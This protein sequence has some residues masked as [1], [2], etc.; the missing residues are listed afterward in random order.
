MANQPKGSS[1]RVFFLGLLLLPNLAPS[2]LSLFDKPWERAPFV[3]F[4]GNGLWIAHLGRARVSRTDQRG[5]ISFVWVPCL[6]MA[7]GALSW[8]WISQPVTA[9]NEGF[10]W[11]GQHYAAMHSYFSAGTYAPIPPEFP[12]WQRVGLPFLAAA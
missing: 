6:I 3:Y 11:D 4:A 2:L 5:D 12:Y 7:L 8:A 10:G 9:L 1:R